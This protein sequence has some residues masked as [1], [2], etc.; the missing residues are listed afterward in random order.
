MTKEKREIT[1]ISEDEA[2]CH[3]L[4]NI[5]EEMST[6]FTRSQ[7]LKPCPIGSAVSGI[8]CKNCAMGPCR[9]KG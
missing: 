1:D 8:C 7:S 3:L 9:I 6:V 2:V 5:D 4:E